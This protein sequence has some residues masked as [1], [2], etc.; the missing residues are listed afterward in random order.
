M[1][2][3]VID[4]I[5]EDHAQIKQMMTSVETATTSDAKEDAF[6]ALV[7]KL[8]IHETAEEEVV[9]PLLRRTEDGRPVTDELLEEEDQGKKALAELESMDVNDSAFGVKFDQL[10]RDV[11]HHAED[12]EQREHPRLKATVDENRL[13]DLTKVF[14]AAEQTAPTHSHKMAPESATGNMVAGPFVA[15]ADRARDAIRSAMDH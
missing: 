4:A 10:R 6:H 5:L 15:I 8:A 14:R 7:R 13:R 12:E 1:A 11:L 9:H 2:N 3:D